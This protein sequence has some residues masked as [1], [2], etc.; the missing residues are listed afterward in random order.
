M[1]TSKSARYVATEQQEEYDEDADF[2]SFEEPAVDYVAAVEPRCA[3]CGELLAWHEQTCAATPAPEAA[4]PRHFA[5]APAL[6]FAYELGRVVQPAPAAP[7]RTI[8]WRG[9]LR[10][11]HP[12]TGL[13]HRVPVYRLDDGYWD[14]Y[15]EEELRVA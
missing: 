6:A 10:E 7:T 12:Q 9:Q 13:V 4:A 14:C 8:V 15:R 3:H 1:A 2:A 5:P 11:R